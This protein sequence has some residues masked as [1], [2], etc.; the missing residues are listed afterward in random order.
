M[1]AILAVGRRDVLG[2]LVDRFRGVRRCQ[3]YGLPVGLIYM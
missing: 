2:L 1:K 3:T